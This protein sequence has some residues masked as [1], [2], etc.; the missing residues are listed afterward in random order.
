MNVSDERLQILEFVKRICFNIITNP[1]DEKYRSIHLK[2]IKKKFTKNVSYNLLVNLMLNAGFYQTQN[3]SRLIFNKY[4]LNDL[5][6]FTD[7]DTK[8]HMLLNMGF[9][10]D[11]SWMALRRC[12]GNVD[13]AIQHILAQNIQQQNNCSIN[14]CQSSHRLHTI[15]TK[16]S[17]MSNNKANS[18]F[19]VS[20]LND[21]HHILFSHHSDADFKCIYDK[22]DCCNMLKCEFR[23]RNYR[24]RDNECKLETDTHTTLFQQI[25][26]KIHCYVMHSYD[27]GHR[28]IPSINSHPSRRICKLSRK[29]TNTPDCNKYNQ[30]TRY[31]FGQPFYYW[32]HYETNTYP[33]LMNKGYTYSDW[34]IQPKYKSLKEEITNNCICTLNV[35]T[36]QNEYDKVCLHIQTDF[37]KKNYIAK[38]SSGYQRPVHNTKYYGIRDG[39]P[40][41]KQ[42]LTSVMIYCCYTNLSYKFSETFRKISSNKSKKKY[43][44]ILKSSV[45]II[46]QWENLAKDELSI[47]SDTSLKERHSN[48]HHMAKYL[49]EAT[50]LFSSTA[51][52][53]NIKVFYHGINQ[54]MMFDSIGQYMYQP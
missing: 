17:K 39:T 30:L 13:N 24:V 10:E 22:F 35:S 20:I 5:I 28:L 37:C 43:S 23:R 44:N 50:N 9:Q 8:L 36:W 2:A 51:V 14:Y 47:E 52:D 41:T 40:I 7:N 26:D 32:K 1:G 29:C 3:G 19:I 18:F 21:F 48:F 49:I 53:G 12:H 31:N 54:E 45:A 33:D 46:T 27:L 6:W 38:P 11:M 34:Y 25:I 4:K 16:F 15:L 42:H